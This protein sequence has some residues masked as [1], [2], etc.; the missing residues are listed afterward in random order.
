MLKWFYENIYNAVADFFS[1]MGNMGAD[2][3]T[4]FVLFQL[5]NS[6]NCRELHKESI[7][8]HL[9]KNKIMLI[10]VGITFV[11][12]ILIIQ[13]AGAFFGTLPLGIDVWVKVIA[14]SFSVIVISE[15]IKLF[16]RLIKNK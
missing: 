12:Q 8:K 5:F 7:F 6:F 16:S 11:L 4:L 10:V 14:L 2:I 9:L 15:I 1:M 13:F 3:F